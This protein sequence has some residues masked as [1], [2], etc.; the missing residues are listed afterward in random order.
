MLFP[1]SRCYQFSLRCT[2]PGVL[3]L[4]AVLKEKPR[5]RVVAGMRKLKE[6]REKRQKRGKARQ[7]AKK[8]GL[9]IARFAIRSPVPRSALFLK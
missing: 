5:I 2:F 6:K 1:I 4:P 9:V 7:M 3:H 8:W